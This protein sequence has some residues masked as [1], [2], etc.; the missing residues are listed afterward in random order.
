MWFPAPRCAQGLHPKTLPQGST[1]QLLNMYFLPIDDEE[2]AEAPNLPLNPPVDISDILT[3]AEGML[4]EENDQLPLCTDQYC[5]NGGTCITNEVGTRLCAC[6]E[7]FGGL[8]CETGKCIFM[9]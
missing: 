1:L 7:G 3:I 2:T 4:Y 9:C 6:I 5:Q 8:R